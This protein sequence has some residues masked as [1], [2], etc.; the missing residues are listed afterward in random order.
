M[1]SHT[2][3]C[4]SNADI[5]NVEEPKVESEGVTFS[6]LLWPDCILVEGA[7]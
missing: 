5:G 6:S 3:G 4:Y 1:E 7:V 2:I